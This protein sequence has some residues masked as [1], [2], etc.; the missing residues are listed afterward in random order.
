MDFTSGY[1]RGLAGYLL[2]AVSDIERNGSLLHH[3][4][5]EQCIMT[6]LLLSHP[7]SYSEALRRLE[8]SIAP[9]DV[10]RAI[11]YIEAHLDTDLTIADIARATGV[12]GR[13]LFKNF[14]DF[15]GISPMRYVRNARFRVVRQALLRAAPEESVSRIAMSWNF[16]HMGRFS[17]E[18]RQRFGES[19]SQTLRRRRRHP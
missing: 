17:V 16:T 9:R 6:G 11:D 7:H 8:K 4:M 12:A 2:T 5:F 3:P 13:T 14:K 18:Y 10:R 19:P 15:K 1:G